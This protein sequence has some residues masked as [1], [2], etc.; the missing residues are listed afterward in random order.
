MEEIAAEFSDLE[1]ARHTELVILYHRDEDYRKQPQIGLSPKCISD[2]EP[3]SKGIPCHDEAGFPPKPMH[4]YPCI[5]T[6]RRDYNE[7]LKKRGLN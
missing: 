5:I 6:T 2:G 1:A 4:G 7:Y 3:T